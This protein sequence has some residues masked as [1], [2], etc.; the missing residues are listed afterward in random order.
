MPIME[1]RKTKAGHAGRRVKGLIATA[2]GVALLLGGTTFALWTTSANYNSP[3]VIK[4][5]DMA[6]AATGDI[7]FYDVSAD[8]TNTDEDTE[9]ITGR[10][11]HLIE[12]LDAHLIVPGDTIAVVLPFTVT[13]DGANLVG[14]LSGAIAQSTDDLA[15]YITGEYSVAH[16]DDFPLVDETLSLA[17]GNSFDILTAVTGADG[18]DAGEGGVVALADGDTNLRLIVFITFPDTGAT[19]GLDGAGKSLELGDVTLTLTQIR[20]SG[21]GQFGTPAN[22]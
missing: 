11:G 1:N 22:P 5:G 17:A 2:A 18:E 14:R 8:R 12:D 9:A 19:Q 10:P 4:A 21:K 16:G 13:M 20:D 15:D 7:A 6:V 3:S